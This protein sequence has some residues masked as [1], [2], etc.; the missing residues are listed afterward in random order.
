MIDVK[1]ETAE[2]VSDVPSETIFR[3][4]SVGLIT[5]Q[6]ARRFLIVAEYKSEGPE[7]GQGVAMREE[8]ADKYC[9]SVGTIN[10]YLYS[11]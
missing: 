8:L 6:A 3:L 9:V 1:K 5:E 10:N 11:K 7:R 2:R 4:F